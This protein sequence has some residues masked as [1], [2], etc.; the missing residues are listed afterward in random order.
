[1]KELICEFLSPTSME[2]EIINNLIVLLFSEL[3]NVYEN[4]NVKE[5][6]GHRKTCV[7][8]I[9]H[10]IEENFRECTLKDTA[11]IFGLNANYMTTLLKRMTGYSFKELVME[12]RLQFAAGMILNT[13]LACDKIITM[14]GC[15]NGTYFY[16]KFKEA[17]HE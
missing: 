5:L 9:M 10:Y 14:S 6:A 3:V 2:K 13:D 11:E 17:T 1:M 16:K 7:V 4:G 8:P 12:Q 15:G